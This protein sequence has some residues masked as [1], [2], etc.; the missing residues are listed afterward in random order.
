MAKMTNMPNM[1]DNTEMTET[2]SKR[3]ELEVLLTVLLSIVSV[4]ALFM[5]VELATQPYQPTR[6]TSAEVFS[7]VKGR[8]DTVNTRELGI[9]KAMFEQAIEDGGHRVDDSFVQIWTDDGLET[10]S[11]HWRCGDQYY[12]TQVCGND[13]YYPYKEAEYIQGWYHSGSIKS[14]AYQNGYLIVDSDIEV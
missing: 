11:F 4:I 1:A 3:S 5:G 12:C 8:I 6:E 10:I 7:N 13:Q 14:V 2:K 9:A